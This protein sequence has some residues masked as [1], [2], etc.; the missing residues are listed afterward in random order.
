MS[1]FPDRTPFLLDVAGAMEALA[2]CAVGSARGYR[3]GGLPAAHRELT[4][5]TEE[6]GRMAD[7]VHALNDLGVDG[8]ALAGAGLDLDRFLD[9]LGRHLQA[10][11]A[12][13]AQEDWLLLA[14]V[15]EWDL[16]P[17]LRQWSPALR[18]L[19][20]DAVVTA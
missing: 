14:D 11:I 8:P 5:L 16:E 3:R 2:S 19:A 15:L 13:H 6:L 10:A 20:G 1:S 17:L 9:G 18:S 7:V 12:A 4:R